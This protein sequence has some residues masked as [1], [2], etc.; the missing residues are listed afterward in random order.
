MTEAF[1]LLLEELVKIPSLSGQEAAASN[2]L[3][4]WML[5]HDMWGFVDGVGNVVGGKGG[6]PNEII[7][8]GHIDTFPGQLPV[9]RQDNLLFG[10]GSV[11]AKG[12]LCAFAAAASLVDVP[13][14]WRLTVVGAVEEETA[15]SKGA[16]HLLERRRLNPPRFCV[17]GEPSQWD[18]LTLGYKGRL[19]LHLSLQV[20]FS[21]SAGPGQLPAEC[22]VNLWQAIQEYANSINQK[23]TKA[24]DKLDVAL[25]GFNSLDQGAFGQVDLQIGFRLPE[26]I[27]PAELEQTLRE[28]ITLYTED[29]PTTLQFES[30][31]VAY[32]AAKSTPLV[33]AFLRA[34]RETDGKPRF[35]LKTG[36]ADMNVVAPVWQCPILAYGPGDSS[37]DHTPEEHL[38]LDDYLKSID[39]LRHAL[40]ALMAD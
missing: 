18:R 14:G 22:G 19:L 16:R 24:F 9:Y 37:L 11:D 32:R 39:V 5:N 10:R 26:D 7:L 15:G 20:P 33:R 29:W 13:P 36:T 2:Y 27:A 21:H 12:P 23:R 38:N 28:L 6:G 34:I 17:I 4:Q 25:R 1:T 31:E 30:H 35:V 3:A 8:L 40:A